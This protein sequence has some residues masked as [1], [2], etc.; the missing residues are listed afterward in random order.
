MF[1]CSNEFM[2]EVRTTPP[3]RLDRALV[4]RGLVS[5]RARGEALIRDGGVDVNGVIVMSKSFL[6]GTADLV[7]LLKGDLEWVSRA[8]LKLASALEHWQID[9][10]GKVALDIGAST[11]GFTEVLL[12]RGAQK[13]YA[14]DV[15]HGQLATKLLASTKVV[16]ME[17]VHIKDVSVKDFAEPIDMI[18]VDVSFISLEKVLPK[19]KALLHAGGI[20][21]ALIKPQFEVGKEH[22]GKGVV[23]DPKLHASVV[24]RIKECATA[25]GFAV[26]GVIASPILGGDGN[27]E[28]LLYTNLTH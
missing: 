3:E 13:V 27:K 6:V 25:L 17:S 11:G 5:S 18:V 10:K 2:E 21:I 20:L 1:F 19:A 14:L 22:V 9:P 4:T 12:S 15:G 28:F 23:T 24:D 26:E 16:N 8:A 7:T